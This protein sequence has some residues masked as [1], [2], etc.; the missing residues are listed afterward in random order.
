VNVVEPGWVRTP[1]TEN[2][3]AAE[4]D[5]AMNASLLKKFIEPA[6][7]ANAVAYLCGPGG[8][9]VTGQIL[10]VDAGQVL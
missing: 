6:D 8:R 7:I 1:L 2:V 5:A 4:R 9:F 10:R 3:P